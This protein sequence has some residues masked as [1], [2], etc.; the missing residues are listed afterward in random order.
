MATG[1]AEKPHHHQIVSFSFHF[2]HHHHHHQGHGHEGQRSDVRRRAMAVPKGCLGVMVGQ[3]GEERQRFVIPV[4]YVNH[5]LF[6]S[7]LKEAEEEFGFDQKGPISIPCHVEEFRSVQDLIHRDRLHHHHHR[8]HLPC[9][10]QVGC[11]KV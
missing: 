11:F 1:A 8:F 9:R 7:L 4:M 3:E 5:P 10:H 2:L 6:G